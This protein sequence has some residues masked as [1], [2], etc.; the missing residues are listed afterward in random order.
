MLNVY[1]YNYSITI[2]FQNLDIFVYMVD[3]NTFFF[4]NFSFWMFDLATT[5]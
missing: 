4:L 5:E 1:S 3:L 2:R